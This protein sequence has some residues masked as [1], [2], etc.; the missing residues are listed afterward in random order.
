MNIT[1]FKIK[2]NQKEK[3]RMNGSKEE[4]K[5]EAFSGCPSPFR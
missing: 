4:K 5:R 1:A 3:E 2:S